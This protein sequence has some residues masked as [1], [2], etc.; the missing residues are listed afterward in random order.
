MALQPIVTAIDRAKP[1]IAAVASAAIG[2]MVMDA[3]ESAAFSSGGGRER[4][5]GDGSDGPDVNQTWKRLKSESPCV[6][7][8]IETNIKYVL[9][10][11]RDFWYSKD[12]ARHGGAAFKRY[13]NTSSTME[14]M[15]SVGVDLKKI[16]KQESKEGTSIKKK[17][18]KIV[19]GRD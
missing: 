19:S 1:V 12:F 9:S 16:D 6:R 2:G 4:K 17:D 13:K 14:F 5:S 10:K 15:D 3:V 18:T 7:K 8:H 11:D